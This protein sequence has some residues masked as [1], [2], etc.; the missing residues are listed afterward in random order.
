MA[1]K[2]LY[3][4]RVSLG[5]FRDKVIK[6]LRSLPA[7]DT[8]TVIALEILLLALDNDCTLTYEGVEESF[9]EELALELGESAE[10]V[11]VTLRYLISKGWIEEVS[12]AELFALKSTE[13]S[14]SESGSTERVRRY[15]QRRKQIESNDVSL[16]C[17]DDVTDGNENVTLER[18][19]K[20]EETRE[21]SEREDNITAVESSREKPEDSQ[22]EEKAPALSL[23]LNSVSQNSEELLGEFGNVNLTADEQVSLRRQFGQEIVAD[24]IGRLSRHMKKNGKGFASHHAVILDWIRQDIASGKTVV[25]QQPSKRSGDSMP[26]NCPKCGKPLN[27]VGTCRACNLQRERHKDGTYSFYEVAST[28]D[29]ANAFKTAFGRGRG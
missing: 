12:E 26:I 21:K 27:E 3:W 23:T 16:Q 22:P 1:E 9:S 15:R 20:R 2:R 29:I 17:N 11:D 18:R 24:Y 19:E 5:F 28:E 10:A 13:L 6:K 25:P 4:L 7:G 8:Y 14:G